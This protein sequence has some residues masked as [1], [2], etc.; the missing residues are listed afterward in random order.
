MRAFLSRRGALVGVVGM[1]L[2]LF[3]V[4]WYVRHRHVSYRPSQGSHSTD[5][6]SPFTPVAPEGRT[7]QDG[8]R[9]S[10]KPAIPAVFKKPARR[11]EAAEDEIA[12][13]LGTRPGRSG[14]QALIEMIRRP[15]TDDY[16]RAL[17][18]SAV[19]YLASA[20][21]EDVELMREGQ[22]LVSQ[23]FLHD[24][25]PWVQK[26]SISVV[27]GLSMYL[28]TIEYTDD[29]Q[30]KSAPVLIAADSGGEDGIGSFRNTAKK[31]SLLATS[32]VAMA[33]EDKDRSV[34]LAAVNAL[35]Y[36]EQ[37]E[38]FEGLLR[39]ATAAGKDDTISTHAVAAIAK[40]SPDVSVPI[41]DHV[42]RRAESFGEKI[43]AAQG[44]V[45]AGRG[46]DIVQ[47]LLSDVTT[48]QDSPALSSWPTSAAELLSRIHTSEPLP[49]VLAGMKVA[50]GTSHQ[51]S[52]DAALNFVERTKCV[53]LLPQLIPLALNESGPFYSRDQARY[54]MEVLDP[55]YLGPK[56]M[57]GQLIAL[58]KRLGADGISPEERERLKEIRDHMAKRYEA[59]IKGN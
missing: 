38:A 49:E 32:L 46:R 48:P 35:G 3:G 25:D 51:A 23:E 29:N 20:A 58:D 14:F 7:S 10:V 24:K 41:L 1:A 6:G 28:Q 2:G 9:I 39:I 40:F 36:S 8:A 30:S 17:R 33:M 43:Y 5:V 12:R 45:A 19:R 21:K 52:V 53:E 42:Y 16:E 27:L 4:A 37:R 15:S 54:L 22:V 57:K 44:L 47:S 26:A 11:V 13:I 59:A 55:D 31:D 50:L 56:S 34:R 18:A